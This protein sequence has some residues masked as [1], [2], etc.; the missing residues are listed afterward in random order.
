MGPSAPPPATGLTPRLRAA[1]RAAHAQA[2]AGTYES[3][4]GFHSTF[5]TALAPVHLRNALAGDPFYDDVSSVLT[6]HNAG[7]QGH[8]GRE[9]L[10]E[11]GIDSYVLTESCRRVR[12]DLGPS[13]IEELYTDIRKLAETRPVVATIGSV[14]AS[15]G[16]WIA[17][18]ADEI[19]ATPTTITGSPG[20]SRKSRWNDRPPSGARSAKMPR[21]RCLNSRISASPDADVTS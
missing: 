8:L 15:G 10:D 2:V 19:W 3:T 7:Y 17:M 6:V 14:A 4:R 1:T 12:D 18:A 20:S 11:L 9:A 16:Y 13:S 21:R 5:L